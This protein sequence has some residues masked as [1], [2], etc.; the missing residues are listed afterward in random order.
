MFFIQGTNKQFQLKLNK[1]VKHISDF[2]QQ[3]FSIQIPW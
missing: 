2:T 3:S 1:R